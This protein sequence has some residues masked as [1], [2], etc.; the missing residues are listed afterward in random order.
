MTRP[1]VPNPTQEEIQEACKKIQAE[2]SESEW[3]RR[4]GLNPARRLTE[5]E[6]GIRT[7]IVHEDGRVLRKPSNLEHTS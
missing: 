4:S 5:L 1:Q 7:I 2:W 3:L 6:S